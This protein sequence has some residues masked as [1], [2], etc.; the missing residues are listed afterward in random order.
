MQVRLGRFQ[1]IRM[2]RR[3][4]TVTSLSAEKFEVWELR[5]VQTLLNSVV[6]A[7]R[8]LTDS[9]LDRTSIL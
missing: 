3:R 5:D 9:D 4:R 6:F 7:F 2:L 1:P 8:A